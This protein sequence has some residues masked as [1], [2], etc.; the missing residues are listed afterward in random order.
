MK[1]KITDKIDFVVTYLDGADA[2]WIKEKAKYS[3]EAIEK[4]LNSEDRFRNLENFHYWF[5]AV[6]KYAPWVNKIH[7]ITWGHVPE[8]LDIENP[9]LNIVN[10]EDYIEDKYLPTFNS[11]VI[12][13]NL[14]QI[15]ELSEQFVNFN[16]DMFLCSETRAEDFFYQGQPRLQMM[17]MPI[18]AVEKFSSVLFNNTLV[19]NQ[20]PYPKKV[21]NKKM[22][23][24]KNGLFSVLSNIYLTPLLKYFDKFMGFMPDHLPYALSKSSMKELKTKATEPFR[25]TSNHKFRTV[26]D[27]NIWLCQDY[28]RA[29]GNFYPRNSFKFGKLI[30]VKRG[31]DYRSAL[32]S[33]YK[34]VCINDSNCDISEFVDEKN[35]ILKLLEEKFPEKSKF[36]K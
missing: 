34:V 19:L 27:I 20:L 21:L 32:F 7:L 28:L 8:W 33:K 13:L 25:E 10:H 5:R 23:S 16:D 9:K 12:E 2:E 35:T 26:S 22:Y 4:T 11:N 17:Y 14:D 36:E 1:E 18:Q 31:V 6:E 15:D 24:T 29:T 3:G 30:E